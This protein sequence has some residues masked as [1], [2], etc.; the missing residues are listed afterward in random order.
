M[1]M[2]HQIN[3][4]GSKIL[5]NGLKLSATSAAT[6]KS[7]W[8]YVDIA[9]NQVDSNRLQEVGSDRLCAEW[10]IKNGGAI[11]TVDLPNRSFQNYNALPRED[12][13][14]KIKMVDATN[15]SIMKIGLEHFKGC[16][17][18]DTVIIHQCKHLE[19]DGLEGLR[20]LKNTLKV[21]QVS[22]C[23]NITD[24]DLMVIGELAKLELLKIV[25]MRYVK[26]LKKVEKNLKAKLPNCVMEIK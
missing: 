13:H 22:G 3:H 1:T 5:Q 26:D 19:S 4:F 17:H 23:D 7:L 14:F 24:E 25:Q 9:F 18:I 6:R 11:R 12:D 8:G 10:L 16:H 21:L 20:Y 15:S 2:L